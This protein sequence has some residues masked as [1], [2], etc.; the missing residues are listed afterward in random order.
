LRR[1]GRIAGGDYN[2]D[3]RLGCPSFVT[4]PVGDQVIQDPNALDDVHAYVENIASW[5]AAKT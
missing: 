4:E 3:P 1:S 2:W 5:L